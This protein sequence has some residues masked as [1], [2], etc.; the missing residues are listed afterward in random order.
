MD[1]F[2]KWLEFAIIVVVIVFVAA[3]A[4]V[5]LKPFVPSPTPSPTVTPFPI[6]SP[7]PTPVIELS[8]V[9]IA[10]ESESFLDSLSENGV[11]FDTKECSDSGECSL[12]ASSAVTTF[13]WRM[14][15]YSG[16]YSAT[17]KSNY[18]EL[19]K[20]NYRSFRNASTG[21]NAFW[22][23]VQV[24]EAFRVTQE[25]E[26]AKFL[27]NT[28]FGLRSSLKYDWDLSRPGSPMLHAIEARE[29]AIVYGVLGKD[30]IV[31]SLRKEKAVFEN[32]TL[33]EKDRAEFLNQS[34]RAL[35]AAEESNKLKPAVLQD[36]PEFREDSCWIQ[37]AK[38]ELYKATGE[39]KY[40]RELQDFFKKARFGTRSRGEIGFVSLGEV[41]PCTEVL[42]ELASSVASFAK[43]LNF[44]LQYFVVDDWDSS[45]ARKC[46]G[47]NGFMAAY[48]S[49]EN[50]CG[51]NE[52]F[53]SDA[54]YSIFVL[55]RQKSV[56]EVS[57]G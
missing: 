5:S 27:Y 20:E 15:A 41:T 29:L 13:A 7:S 56:F 34:L 52:K 49:S 46:N 45:R 18:L 28:G 30:E 10:R 16:L 2:S 19:V 4:L 47:D 9:Q 40:L 12:S 25:I 24:Y 1:S 22:S 37:A 3:F 23:L 35:A 17:N 42:H 11:V 38:L 6:A 48:R 44:L 14:L 50:A 31:S 39:E 32:Q 43:D 57:G 36:M 54:C 33:F 53:T 8:G 26:Y 21:V 55:S 51:G